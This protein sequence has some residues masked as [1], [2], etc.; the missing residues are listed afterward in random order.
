[1]P[2]CFG[3]SGRGVA[4]RQRTIEQCRLGGSTRK[5]WKW[6]SVVIER[7]AC[8]NKRGK[9]SSVCEVVTLDKDSGSFKQLCLSSCGDWCMRLVLYVLVGLLCH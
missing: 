4:E 3:G 6:D 9:G 1:M 5:R 2:G 8:T 7:I